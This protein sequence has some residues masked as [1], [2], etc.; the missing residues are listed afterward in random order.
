[1]FLNEITAYSHGVLDRRTAK[2]V[3]PR[4]VVNIGGPH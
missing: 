1:M 3:A 4:A 2:T